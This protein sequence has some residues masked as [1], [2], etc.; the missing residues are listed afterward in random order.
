MEMVVMLAAGLGCGGS[1]AN[2]GNRHSHRGNEC[3]L[4]HVLLLLVLVITSTASL[5][6][7]ADADV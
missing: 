7:P 4:R 5:N 2:G 3:L 1:Q 6:R